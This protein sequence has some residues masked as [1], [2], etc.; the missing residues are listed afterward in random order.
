MPFDFRVAAQR[1]EATAGRVDQN[2][3]VGA[4]VGAWQR[5]A[6]ICAHGAHR[7]QTQTDGV[8]ADSLNAASGRIDGNQFTLVFHEFGEM[9]ALATGGG[10][11]VKNSLAGQ[12]RQ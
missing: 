10:A 4:N 2:A 7:T 8:F 6:R 9:R 11:G 12:R 1:A 5:L 3:I